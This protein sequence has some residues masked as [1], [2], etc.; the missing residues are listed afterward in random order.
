MK[1]YHRL[2]KRQFSLHQLDKLHVVPGAVYY[3]VVCVKPIL[4]F[5]PI[6]YNASLPI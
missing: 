1:Q 2:L 4:Y 3:S 6:I 5:N